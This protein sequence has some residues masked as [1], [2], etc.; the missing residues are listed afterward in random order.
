[1]ACQGVFT[2]RRAAGVQMLGPNYLNCL[3]PQ[4]VW[5]DKIL[6]DIVS[7]VNAIF[8][9]DAEGFNDSLETLDRGLPEFST[10]F[11]GIDDALKVALDGQG[12]DF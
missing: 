7:N 5:S 12:F 2:C 1:M 11:F 4:L 6:Y 8:R 10:H 3:E 9:F